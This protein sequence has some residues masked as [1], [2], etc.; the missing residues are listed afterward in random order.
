MSGF[1]V[2]GILLGVIPLVFQ[3]FLEVSRFLEEYR[4]VER[5]IWTVLQNI[6]KE[7]SI[8]Q[9]AFKTLLSNRFES[10]EVDG[11]LQKLWDLRLKQE[12]DFRLDGIELHSAKVI[13][14]ALES[15]KNTLGEVRAILV[16]LGPLFEKVD[17]PTLHLMAR[18]P[19]EVCFPKLQA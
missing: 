9:M 6:E 8:F 16:K 18:P 15:S 17:K 12:S 11:L 1:E 19:L 14:H 7:K 3:G 5:R 10:E 13:N 4:G 2:A